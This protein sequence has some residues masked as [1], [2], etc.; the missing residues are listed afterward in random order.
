MTDPPDPRETTAPTTAEDEDLS[1]IDDSPGD[2]ELRA[3]VE[4]ALDLTRELLS[5]EDL[6]EQRRMLFSLARTHPRFSTWLSD[7]R[8]RAVPD[9]SGLVQKKEDAALRASIA[10]RAAGGGKGA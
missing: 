1:E 3:R 9:R 6:E 7:Q 4:E 2:A 5:P 8:P 10:R